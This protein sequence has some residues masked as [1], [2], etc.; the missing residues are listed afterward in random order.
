DLTRLKTEMKKAGVL[1]GD[2][3]LLPSSQAKRLVFDA[4]VLTLIDGPFAESKELIGGYSVLKMGSF[5]EV[6]AECKEYA[7]ILG[8]TLEIDVRV[9]DEAAE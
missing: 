9:V 2:T 3:A 5:D 7:K 8:G 6:I 1:G 4:N